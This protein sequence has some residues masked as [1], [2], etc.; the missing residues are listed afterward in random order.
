M[1]RTTSYWSALPLTLGVLLSSAPA[2]SIV[3][4]IRPPAN[5]VRSGA[6]E[7]ITPITGGVVFSANDSFGREPWFSDGTPGGTRL[8]RDLAPGTASSAPSDFVSTGTRVFFTA[9]VEGL[10]RELY[11]TDGTTAGTRLVRDFRPGSS[12][13]IVSGA[14]AALN[15]KLFFAAH[16]GADGIE[17]WVSDGT[18]GGTQIHAQRAGSAG[19]SPTW[20]TA[21]GGQLY[22]VAND[23]SGNQ[24]WSTDGVAGSAA[25]VGGSE[26]SPTNL[27]PFGTGV[28]YGATE[29]GGGQGVEPFFA[30]ATLGVVRSLGDIRPGGSSS[31]A[32]RFVDLGGIALF[33]ANDGTH[34]V[35]LWRTDGTPAGTALVDDLTAGAAATSF[36]EFVALGNRAVFRANASGEQE[37]WESDGTALNTRQLFDV[38]GA[39]SSTNPSDL[40][41]LGNEVFFAGRTQA[42]GTELFK[43][44]GTPGGTGLAVEFVAG[45]AGGS[46]QQVVSDGAQ[47]WLSVT[48]N[49]S[50]RELWCGDG[51][52]PGTN[53][54]LDIDPPV[55]SSEIL[56]MTALGGGVVFRAADGITTQPWYSDGTAPGTQP[57]TPGG[58]QS[59]L[60]FEAWADRVWFAGFTGAT[61]NELWSTAGSPGSTG[62]AFDRRALAASLS[63][64]HLRAFGTRMLFSGVDH[65]QRE[66]WVTD[67]TLGGTIPLAAIHPAGNSVVSD[68]QPTGDVAFFVAYEPGFGNELWVTDGTP[69]G[70]HRV[71]D[72]RSGAT[73]SNPVHLAAFDTGR[74]LFAAHDGA[75]GS[76]PWV[77]DGTPGGTMPVANLVSGGGSSSPAQFVSDGVRGWFEAH[78]TGSGRELFV[79]DGTPGGTS[80]ITEI[81]PGGFDAEI[82][83][84]VV[85]GDRA[86]FTAAD[87]QH[88]VELWVSDGTPAGSR[89]VLD[90]APGPR[91]GVLRGTLTP[92]GAGRFVVF[93]A[94]DGG[95]GLQVWGSDGTPGSTAQIG[96]IG[97]QPGVGAASIR[98]F[99]TAGTNVF[100][101]CDD[102][103][104]GEEAWVFSIPTKGLPGVFNFGRGCAGAG[105]PVPYLAAQGL[106]AIGN[107]HFGVRI[108]DGSPA[109]GAGVLL[110]FVPTS[111]PLFGCE[112]YLGGSVL[113]LGTSFTNGAGTAWIPFP[114]PLDPSAVGMQ[115]FLQGAV[116]ELGAPFL[117][118]AS[119]T[120]GMQVSVGQ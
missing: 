88:G 52:A 18:Q 34:G 37:L 78:T 16:D 75:T 86:F 58:T 7:H 91:S 67:G 89:L 70:T 4:D 47:L 59:P 73:S 1:H 74:V 114:I 21:A 113:T 106:P 5:T 102:A 6:P 71:A 48:Q 25:P 95:D 100:F 10:G 80:R 81:G 22:F 43:T 2:Q 3:R 118:V 104:H 57:L 15:G 30:D 69:A 66:P 44:D 111:I 82:E 90:L 36:G 64:Q 85:A 103:T 17:L 14:S 32:T 63:P 51:T 72:I 56:D 87:D 19:L 60:E 20:L 110:S 49:G 105:D 116:L 28:L 94:S 27:A 33:T 42:T 41:V 107:P 99:V 83:D 120:H 84:L 50:G 55:D 12:S 11:V 77:S 98:D 115:V 46:P 24:V 108:R 8:L 93:A 35:E 101:V 61:G 117:G 40:V 31:S 96:R 79:T 38:S 13:G 92:V 9:V 29:P 62:L 65:N 112:F 23:G 68:F 39:G 76:E 26:R 54:V 119:L 53:L 45:G 97:N 109:A